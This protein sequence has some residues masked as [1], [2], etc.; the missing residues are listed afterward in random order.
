[1]VGQRSSAGF[2]MA[3]V[4]I[5]AAASFFAHVLIGKPV[6]TLDQVE[7]MLFRDMRES[8]TKRD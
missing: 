3:L 7:G 4:Q 6:L 5:L 2:G 1:M 8:R